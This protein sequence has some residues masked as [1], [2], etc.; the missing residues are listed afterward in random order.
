MQQVID[1]NPEVFLSVFDI[2]AATEMAPWLGEIEAPS[3]VLTGE[4][5]GGCPPRLNE[6]IA[7]TMP[8]AELVVLPNLR[9]AILLEAPDQVAPPLMKF[10][11]Q[12]GSG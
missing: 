5:D 7:R 4:F 11:S 6:F 1:C 12:H 10:L 8:H 3:L 2:Y 9:H